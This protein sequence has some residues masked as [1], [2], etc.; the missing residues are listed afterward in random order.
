MSNETRPETTAHCGHCEQDVKPVERHGWRNFWAWVAL[1]QFA[2]IIAAIVNTV[3]AVDPDAAGGGIGRLILWPALIHPAWAGI[4][5]AVGA[6]LAA[7][8]GFGLAAERAEKTATCPRC[9]LP[10]KVAG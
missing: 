5:A 10:L 4:A 3:N 6:F 9:G 7:G 2:A 1:L 8:I